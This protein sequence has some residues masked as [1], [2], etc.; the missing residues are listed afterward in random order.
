M[1]YSST[2][3]PLPII[4]GWRLRPWV[5][6]PMSACV[7]YQSNIYISKLLEE[8]RLT[9]ILTFIVTSNIQYMQ[10]YSAKND[11]LHITY[12]PIP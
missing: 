9:F 4:M 12:L 6:D 5:Q 2:V 1:S 3:L 10:K 8:E 7:T 11:M